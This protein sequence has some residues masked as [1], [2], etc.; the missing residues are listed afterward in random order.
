MKNALDSRLSSNS[1]VL[2]STVVG[3]EF[4]ALALSYDEHGVVI[5]SSDRVYYLP[6]TS[7]AWM[8]LRGADNTA[9]DDYDPMDSVL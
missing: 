9:D 5:K 7:V 1:E 6:W 2:I 3:K 4:A 8:E